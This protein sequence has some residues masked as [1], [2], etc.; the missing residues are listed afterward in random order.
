MINIKGTYLFKQKDNIILRGENL[1][2]FLGECFF[3][4]RCI[5]DSYDP[6][7]YI[8]IG[9]AESIPLRTDSKLGNETSRKTCVKEADL[10]NK[11]V[12]LTASFSASDI[13]GTTEIGV[14]ND[15]ILISHDIFEK[16]DN[17]L[18]TNLLG[19]VEVEYTFQFSTSTI[20]TG[21]I[22]VGGN[23]PH[24]YYLYEPNQVIGVTENNTTGYRKLNSKEDVES[25]TASYYY[26]VTTQNIYIH[27]L[28]N[29]NP[30]DE[31]ILIETKQ[32]EGS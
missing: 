21:W 23:Y 26:D 2:T 12:K 20:K 19:T 22:P 15:K 32:Y 11:C 5:N 18:L 29:G 10:I 31:V 7:Q 14:A 1:I 8:V 9:N 24:V 17:K 25:H 3:L 4:N 27:T 28:D 6:I 30:N 16:I 13:V